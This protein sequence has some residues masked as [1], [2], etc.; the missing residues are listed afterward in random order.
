[1]A[2][3]LQ[4]PNHLLAFVEDVAFSPDGKT[5]AMASH[6]AIA[7][8]VYLWDVAAGKLLETLR[9]HSNSVKAVVFSPDGRTL[10]SGG[11][12]RRSASGTLRRGAN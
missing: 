10:G 4:N 6:S 8:N 7:G 3:T 9:G 2:H 11:M 1:M 12:T 5:L